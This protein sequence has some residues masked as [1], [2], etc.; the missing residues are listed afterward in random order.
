MI[1]DV[2]RLN[3]MKYD[4][5][6]WHSGGEFP[7][8]LPPEAGATHS[9]MFLAWAWLNGMAGENALDEASY[10]ISPLQDRAVTPGAHFL[11]QCDGKFVDDDLNDTGNAFAAAYFDF[12]TGDYAMDYESAL[13]GNCETMYH[14]PDTWKSYDTIMPILDRRFAEWRSKTQSS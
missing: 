4:D 9:G 12:E 8:D 3:K 2:I 10:F 1:V 5:A 13:A 7:S 6:S 14:V 11:A